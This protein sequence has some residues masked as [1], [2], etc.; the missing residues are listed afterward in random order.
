MFLKDWDMSDSDPPYPKAAG[1][2]SVY[3][4]QEYYEFL[5]FAIQN[6]S[7]ISSYSIYSLW[8]VSLFVLFYSTSAWKLMLWE[9]ISITLIPAEIIWLIVKPI[10]MKASSILQI[11]GLN[12]IAGQQRVSNSKLNFLV[13][14]FGLKFTIPLSL[15]CVDI[16]INEDPASFSSEEF[17]R[18]NN[19][20][21]NGQ[22]L[23]EASLSFS[24]KAI[25]FRPNE[26][27]LNS[28]DCYLFNLK[29]VFSDQ[30]EDGQ[31]QV[32]LVPD[33]EYIHC[34]GEIDPPVSDSL[35]KTMLSIVNYIVI[36]I[37]LFSFILCVRAVFKA[38]VLKWVIMFTFTL[39][40]WT[41]LC[42]W[43]FKLLLKTRNRFPISGI[44]IVI[45]F[46]L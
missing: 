44:S 7:A 42:N 20:S 10:I 36:F 46:S 8:S 33:T 45:W 30:D 3:N 11:T 41:E 35:S 38:Q 6:V 27:L 28:P 16:S 22:T 34:E 2:L 24:I 17:L 5:D 13:I 37:S 9:L 21:V 18:S 4:K 32:F 1:P 39:F 43:R 40:S 14:I 15:V 19:M 23:V 25:H 26:L 29:L 12:L 31:L